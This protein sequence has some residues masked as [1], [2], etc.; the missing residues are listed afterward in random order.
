MTE[1]YSTCTDFNVSVL[2]PRVV[3]YW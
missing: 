2:V 3:W 1:S